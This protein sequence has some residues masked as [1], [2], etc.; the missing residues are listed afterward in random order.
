MA[1]DRQSLPLAIPQLLDQLPGMVYRCR[2][3]PDWPMV[4]VSAGC[5]AVTGR[6]AEALLSGKVSY[7]QLIVADDRARVWAT[8]QDALV[9]HERFELVYR[10]VRAD[11]ETRW[12]WERGWGVWRASGNE[13]DALEGFVTD[14]TEQKRVEHA[15]RETESIWRALLEAP[16]E[17]VFMIRPDGEV[18]AASQVTASR[19]G[20]RNGSLVGRCIYDLIPAELAASR[21]RFIDEVVRSGKAVCF[22]D[23]REGL[24]LE[25]HVYPIAD[26][27]GR[28]TRLAIYARDIT[29]E[30]LREV[31]YEA[32]VKTSMEG[33]HVVDLQGRIV[34]V[35]DAFCRMLGHERD[36]LLRMSLADIDLDHSC[37][38]VDAHI[39]RLVEEGSER[40]ETRH[41]HA[42]GSAIDVE[43]SVHH[44]PVAGGRLVCF[45]RDVRER[46]RMQQELEKRG[47]TD[48][49]TGLFNRR[50]FFGL[51]QAEF[52]RYRRNPAANPIAAIMVDL[53][54]FKAVND[55]RGHL[56]GDL[57]LQ[58][59]A[60]SLRDGIRI[61]DLLC[62]YGGEEFAV[63][64]LQTRLDAAIALAQ[65]L[66]ERIAEGRVATE[67][68]DVTI[69]ASFGVAALEFGRA[70]SL[71]AL[72]DCADRMLY[73]A[74]R[75][76]RNR[77]RA[78]SHDEPRA[79]GAS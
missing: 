18:I 20:A 63:L 24:C 37:E 6:D 76:G 65:R 34:D 57:V 16:G 22:S 21:R 64:L 67:R 17:S 33:F 58:E 11:G 66:R 72:L 41:R 60:R 10:I 13:A 14:I 49:L 19:L 69:T 53:D 61:N 62:R 25:N 8:I 32:M 47:N 75:A 42:D 38:Q 26:D 28:V 71:E 43:I 4:F 29:R 70:H 2:N 35:N 30:R 59:V 5:Q 27:A 15:L 39:R 36:T 51:A 1:C 68:G 12:V 40:F 50:H 78:C 31:E 46:K 73:A 52:E 77:V 45:S 23:E 56:V 3:E 48:A 74:K 9:R 79:S 44:L 54:H 55:D 7:A